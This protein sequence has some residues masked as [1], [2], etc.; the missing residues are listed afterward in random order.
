L[1]GD[2]IFYLPGVYEQSKIH[3]DVFDVGGGLVGIIIAKYL[4][5]EVSPGKF[6]CLRIPLYLNKACDI[7]ALE[8][9]SG[10]ISL[11]ILVLLLDILQY[12]ILTSLLLPRSAVLKTQ[13]SLLRPELSLET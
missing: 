6:L 12:P 9:D 1:E 5:R 2:H 4:D 11:A 8:C 10:V 7:L 13:E 3:G